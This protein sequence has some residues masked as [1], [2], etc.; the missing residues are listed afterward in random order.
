MKLRDRLAG[1]AALQSGRLT[2]MR[3]AATLFWAARNG[4]ERILLLI[5]G[6]VVVLGLLYLLLID[7]AI[8]GRARLHKNLPVLRQQAAQLQALAKQAVALPAAPAPDAAGVSKARI[9]ALLQKNG[10]QA[11]SVVWSNGFAR[12]QFTQ[13]SFSALLDALQ[14]LQ[15]AT[16]LTVVE[17][18]VTATPDPGSV[19]AS[20]TL[21]AQKAD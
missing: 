9:E 10:L 12:L 1:K 14:A 8:Q 5:A 6:A 11:H 2:A 16:R 7:P 18:S 21:R 3:A 4:R 20:L 13:V 19:N 15:Q 17:A